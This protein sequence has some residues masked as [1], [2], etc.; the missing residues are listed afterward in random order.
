MQRRLVDP[1]RQVGAFGAEPVDD[2]AR[3]ALEERPELGGL[4]RLEL[5]QRLTMLLRLDDDRAGPER[6]DAVL[7]APRRASRRSVPP[8]SGTRP[9]V[10][11]QREAAL[12]VSYGADYEVAKLPEVTA[13]VSR[14][15][16]RR[17]EQARDLGERFGR[18]ARGRACDSRRRRRTS[19]P[20]TAAPAH[21]HRVLRSRRARRAPTRSSPA[22]VVAST[23]TGSIR[24]TFAAPERGGRIRL[25]Q[26]APGGAT[27]T[28]HSTRRVRREAGAGDARPVRRVAYAP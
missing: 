7:G 25:E 17:P 15:R 10:V 6:A 3:D 11:S 26:R 2:C 21:R 20:R 24:S 28:S 22:T 1:H 14:G 27:R 5:P 23:T 18:S 19:S 4:D 9:A 16:H 12:D 13:T 8:G